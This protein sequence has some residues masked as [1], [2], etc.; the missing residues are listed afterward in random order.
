MPSDAFAA[1]DAL[2]SRQ[3]RVGLRI[4]LAVSVGLTFNLATGAVMPFFGPVLAVQFL[5][6]G[7]G[8]MP[9]SQAAGLIGLVLIVGQ[10]F[11]VLSG[12]FGDHPVQ[13]LA[14]LGLFYFVCFFVH[15]RGR[16]GPVI[17]LC[18]M[19]AI[20]VTLLDRVHSTLDSSIIAILLQACLS[21]VVLSWMAHAI[22]P[23][24]DVAQNSPHA[25]PLTG[26]PAGRALA[27]AAILLGSITL[28][29]TNNTLATAIVFP[30]TVTSVLLQSDFAT[31]TR[32]ALTVI[33]VNFL[34]GV[35]A[36]VAFAFVELRPSLLFVFMTVF[37]VG[38]LLGGRA[39]VALPKMYAGALT[40]FLILLGTGISPL[41]T[42]TP[43][44]FST[45]IGYVLLAVAYTLCMI[46]LLW[47]RERTAAKQAAI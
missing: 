7:A 22:L 29:L 9:L 19:L 13:L 14:L 2:R 34:S 27:N 24:H 38:L 21:A 46:A 31:S 30:L 32:S 5:V 45:R 10:A 47:P 20:T 15:A 25:A 40:T 39:A 1:V 36:S 17:F 12:I 18:L 28:C 41:P 8:P 33:A 44:S 3:F 26:R 37:L 16:G 42:T 23:G 35:V 11:I 4:A 43:E 6:S